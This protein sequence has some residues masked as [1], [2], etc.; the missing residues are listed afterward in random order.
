MKYLLS[1]ILFCAA[2]VTIN[3]QSA[4]GTWTTIDDVD[5]KV[6][7]HV[8][9]YEKSGK[10]YGKVSKL[11]NSESST[12]GKCGGAKK[13][14]P[15]EGM[16]I[17]WNLVKDSDTEWEEGN[18]LDPKSGKEYKCK[19]E[20]LDANTLNVRGFIGFSLLGRTQTWYRLE[21]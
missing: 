8:E 17:I 18:I 15:I 7:S 13:D 5:G 4:I 14:Q 12:C 10:L 21:L 6:K 9:I 11:I 20:L 16:E 3:A 2:I 1:F 19:I